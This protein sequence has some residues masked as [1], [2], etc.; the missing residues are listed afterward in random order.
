MF[1]FMTCHVHTARP[2]A[3]RGYL[4]K[5]AHNAF[6]S[7]NRRYFELR[8]SKLFYLKKDSE[9]VSH[10]YMYMNVTNCSVIFTHCLFF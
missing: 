7:W 9:N 4:F 3:F 1:I 8:D 2:I 5:R 6:K 10:L